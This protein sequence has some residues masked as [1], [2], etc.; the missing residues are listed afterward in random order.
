MADQEEPTASL[1]EEP[2]E[3]TE[4]AGDDTTGHN[5]GYEFARQAARDKARET[6]LWAK[7]EALRREAKKSPLDRLR[8]R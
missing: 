2:I 6:D 7:K 8:G 3:A 5:I 4:D 1:S